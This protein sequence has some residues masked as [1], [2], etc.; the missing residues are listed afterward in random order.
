MPE[1]LAARGRATTE[2]PPPTTVFTRLKVAFRADDLEDGPI[3]AAEGQH[4]GGHPE[5]FPVHDGLCPGHDH[6]GGGQLPETDLT[7]PDEIGEQLAGL[8]PE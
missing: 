6:P 7:T 3:S 2:M 5:R 1:S 8:L 4:A